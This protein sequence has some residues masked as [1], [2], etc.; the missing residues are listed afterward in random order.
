MSAR[1]RP[2]ASALGSER[3]RPLGLGDCYMSECRA[4]AWPAGHLS[5]TLGKV[6]A[7]GNLASGIWAGQ[8]LHMN[9]AGPRPLTV[10]AEQPRKTCELVLRMAHGFLPF[11]LPAGTC[12]TGQHS[13]CCSERIGMLLRGG[14]GPRGELRRSA[15]RR[16]RQHSWNHA[17][18]HRS[19]TGW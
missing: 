18:P 12:K 4:M 14:V 17:A 10:W 3:D 11:T 15:R 8:S 9:G 6:R 7:S 1:G 13:W 5:A 2:S 16:H 19:L